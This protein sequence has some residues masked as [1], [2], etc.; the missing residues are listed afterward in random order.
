MRAVLSKTEGVESV[1]V[2]LEK[3]KVC[4]SG[5]ASKDLLMERI[6]KTGKKTEYVG[7]C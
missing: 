5:S 3:Q 7:P 6:G 4:V 2:D 1:D